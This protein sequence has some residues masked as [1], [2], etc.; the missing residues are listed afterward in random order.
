[1]RDVTPLFID[2]DETQYRKTAR[3]LLQLFEDHLDEPKGDLEDAIDELT[4][5]DTDYKIVQGLAKLLKDECEFEVMASVEPREIRRRLFENLFRNA[6]EHGDGPVVTVGR[7]DN[8]EC[9]FYVADDGP[10]IPSEE[11]E[12]VF[13]P[14]YSSHEHGTGLGLSIVKRIAECHDW[15]VEAKN[16]CAGGRFEFRG[17]E[18]EI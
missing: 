13:E 16:G 12:N 3:E 17:I 18:P 14:G 8:S 11:R 6:V 10:G 7:L 5:A 4:V 1:M 9:G 2:P 15:T